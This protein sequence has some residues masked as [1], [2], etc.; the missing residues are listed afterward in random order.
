MGRA[1]TCLVGVQQGIKI[2]KV[3]FRVFGFTDNRLKLFRN[4]T[5]PTSC[6]PKIIIIAVF[7]ASRLRF[8]VFL[9]VVDAETQRSSKLSGVA[10][11]SLTISDYHIVTLFNVIQLFPIFCFRHL[12]HSES[13]TSGRTWNFKKHH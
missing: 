5:V 7:I 11:L 2:E 1:R 8:E 6:T 4:C 3:I 12:G 10:F 13:S 9:G